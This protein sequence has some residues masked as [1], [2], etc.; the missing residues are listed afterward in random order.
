LGK[1]GVCTPAKK[2]VHTPEDT[3]RG[4]ARE[5]GKGGRETGSSADWSRG[6]K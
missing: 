2:N 3:K 1:G 4:E 5:D 6:A